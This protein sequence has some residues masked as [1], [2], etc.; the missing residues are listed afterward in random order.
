LLKTLL[1]YW[2]VF[3]FLCFGGLVGII[4]TVLA[5]VR[6]VRRPDAEKLSPYECGFEPIGD[7][8]GTFHVRFYVVAILF[9]LFD[10]EFIF[11]F[12]WAASL[13]QIGFWGYLSMMVFLFVLTVGFVYEWRKG[14]LEWE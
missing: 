4:F 12:P 1:L 6:G 14:A 8:R 9:V 13:G 11:L 7:L 10:V 5:W 2:P 3:M